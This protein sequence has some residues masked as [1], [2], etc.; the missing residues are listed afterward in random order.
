MLMAVPLLWRKPMELGEIETGLFELAEVTQ[1]MLLAVELGQTQASE[2]FREQLR[3]LMDLLRD[4][5]CH[6]AIFKERALVRLDGTRATIQHE[7]ADYCF[8]N[9]E[10]DEPKYYCEVS[11]TLI[12]DGTRG[13]PVPS[14]GD[15]SIRIIRMPVKEEGDEAEGDDHPPH[16][17]EGNLVNEAEQK[18][19]NNILRR[20]GF[21]TKG[22]EGPAS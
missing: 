10:S 5:N 9:H 18:R 3:A 16:D 15:I 14:K 17:G 1:D 11:V 4:S 8:I 21:D 20:M 12:L 22:L 6:V 19:L 13:H 2:E 7:L